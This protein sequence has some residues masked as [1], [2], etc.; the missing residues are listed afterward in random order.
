MDL[1]NK[2]EKLKKAL[3][4][5]V[6]NL[7]MCIFSL[8][9]SIKSIDSQIIWKVIAS[10]ASFVIFLTMTILVFRQLMRLKKIA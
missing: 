9:M 4:A 6:M 3:T 5:F 10:C 7:I 1:Q 2:T 8:I